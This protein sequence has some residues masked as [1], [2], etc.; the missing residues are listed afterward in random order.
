M[1]EAVI[2]QVLAVSQS[3]MEASL[4]PHYHSKPAKKMLLARFPG[5]DTEICDF[6]GYD[7]CTQF[8]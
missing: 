3:E 5:E 6:E 2:Y 7:P 4:I 1:R 8:P